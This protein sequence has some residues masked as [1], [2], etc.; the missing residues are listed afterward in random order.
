M[1][2]SICWIKTA[3]YVFCYNDLVS[4]VRCIL[5]CIGEGIILLVRFISDRDADLCILGS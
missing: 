1:I 5:I 3:L 2:C 4:V